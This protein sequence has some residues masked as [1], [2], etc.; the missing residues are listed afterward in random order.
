MV[1]IE[2][3]AGVA[4]L[5]AD[6]EDDRLQQVRLGIE[7]ALEVRRE[8]RVQVAERARVLVGDEQ[9]P[10]RLEERVEPVLALLVDL[11][12]RM[13]RVADQ[14]ALPLVVARSVRCR[15]VDATDREP[16]QLAHALGL[17]GAVRVARINQP[18]HVAEGADRRLRAPAPHLGDALHEARAQPQRRRLV[19]R[20]EARLGALEIALAIGV[21]AERELQPRARLGVECAAGL[22]RGRP[23]R[24]GP[25]PRAR[26]SPAGAAAVTAPTTARSARST[27][28]PGLRA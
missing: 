20:A 21:F 25:R 19:D 4:H 28:A 10:R 23:R 12:P 13:D 5:A 16:G 2:R 27:D 1:A 18:N 26:R 14:R 8:Q 6:E 7:G 17:L 11:L 9:R 3:S 24:S 15:V 22:V